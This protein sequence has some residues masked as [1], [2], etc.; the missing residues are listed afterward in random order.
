MADDFR[1]VV[2]FEEDRHGLHFGRLLGE[3][4]FEKDAR[5]QLGDR[6][7]V[8]RDGPHVFLYTGTQE[9]A[10]AAQKTVQQLLAG[11]PMRASVSP[12]LRWHPAEECWE[13]ASGR[14]PQTSEE[15]E[16]E[17][18]RWEEQQAKETRE[19]GY[20]EWEVRVDLPSHRDAVDFAERLEA[21]DITPITR[22]WKYVLI[23]AASDDDAQSLAERLRGEAPK[24]ASVTAEPSATIGWEL[25][26]GNPFSLFGGFGPRP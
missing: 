8:T 16:A 4:E 10:E 23:G 12:I 24:G 22:R 14:L 1:I 15:K 3:R 18:E 6:V 11:D 25:A 2:Q 26:S 5:G 17:H 9:Q 19:L 21:E 20:A 13:D 7:V